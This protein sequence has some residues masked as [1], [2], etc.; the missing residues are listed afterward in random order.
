MEKEI[1]SSENIKVGITLGDI[2][3]I[4]PEIIIKALK[5]NR[6]LSDITPVIY[7][8]SKVISFY[9]KM[10]QIH[11]FSYQNC[12]TGADIQNKKINI[13]NCWN[14]EVEVQPGV[15]NVTGGKYA[16]KSLEAATADLADGKI[17]VLVTAPFSKDAM[18]SAGFDFPGHTEFLAKYSNVDE[19]LMILASPFLRVALVTTHIP[20]NEVSKALTKEAILNKIKVF[21]NSLK[22]DFNLV[23]PKIAV[24]GLNPH[25]GENG[26]IGTEEQEQIIPAINEAKSEGILAFGP[27][28]A[29]GFFGSNAKNQFDGVLAMYHDQGLTA[30]KA[31]SF[32]DG[33]NFSAGLPIVRTSPDHGTA[34]DIAG[35]NLASEA[36]FRS[37]IYLAMDIYRN[38]KFVKQITENPLQIRTEV[39]RERR[40]F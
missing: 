35:K 32:E 18:K 26:K 3:G 13:V 36:S 24:F 5:D 28:A 10:L 16:L 30:F 15:S 34:F 17:D 23:R 29:D 2:N 40:E 1:L 25:A 20:I 9:K 6:I 27:F 4:G 22:R 31:L 21:E 38:R 12:R 7:G 11:E 19:A 14:E 33:V 8:S 37:A 39:V